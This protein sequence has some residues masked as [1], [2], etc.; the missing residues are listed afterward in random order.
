M[1]K[2][3]SVSEKIKNRYERK[4]MFAIGKV[5]GLYYNEPKTFFGRKNDEKIRCGGICM[6]FLYR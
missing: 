3:R 5:F 4:S 1:V 2:R 6:A